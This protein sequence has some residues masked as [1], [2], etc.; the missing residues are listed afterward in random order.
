MPGE[1]SVSVEEDVGGFRRC[2]AHALIINLPAH[3]FLGDMVSS[4]LRY[5]P[6]V[7]REAYKNM[8]RVTDLMETG[9]MFEDLGIP[10]LKAEEDRV[11]ICGSPGMLRDLKHMLE[12]RG[13]VEGNTSRPGDF[14]I[15]RAFAEQ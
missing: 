4:Q 3:E 9:K 7:T 1:G 14:V 2:I 5:Y 8:G 12:G 10:P 13:F 15:E 6:T 11:M